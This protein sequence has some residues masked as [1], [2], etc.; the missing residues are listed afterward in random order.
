[1]REFVFCVLNS[2]QV[3]RVL[4]TVHVLP[5]DNCSPRA[6]HLARPAQCLAFNWIRPSAGISSH[7]TLSARESN[8]AKS[9]FLCPTR[10]PRNTISERYSSMCILLI[11]SNCTALG[12]LKILKG[13]GPPPQA[14]SILCQCKY[15]DS[16]CPGHRRRGT[17]SRVRTTFGSSVLP[18]CGIKKR[19][20]AAS[21]GTS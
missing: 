20:C 13:P 3:A 14:V 10:I 16:F 8:Q 2:V 6:S 1:M 11:P 4:M 15:V 5:P 17:A 9:R 19:V 18:T 7:V 12:H 21:G